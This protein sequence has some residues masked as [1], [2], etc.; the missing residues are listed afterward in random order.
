M[1]GQ[2]YEENYE[3]A[4]ALFGLLLQQRVEQAPWGSGHGPKL[5][6]LKRCLDIAL[7]HRV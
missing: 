4:S 7:R 6:E 1:A 5:L 3:K 2:L